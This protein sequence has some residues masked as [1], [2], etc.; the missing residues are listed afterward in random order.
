MGFGS[1]LCHYLSRLE[2]LQCTFV[3]FGRH[4]LQKAFL[5]FN[6]SFREFVIYVLCVRARQ[7]ARTWL[8]VH[9]SVCRRIRV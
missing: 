6:L 3:A 5:M 2:L 1:R 9:V 8:C 7:C 4:E